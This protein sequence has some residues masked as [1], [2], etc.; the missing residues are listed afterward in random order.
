ME[1][2]HRTHREHTE[3]TQGTH[4]EHTENTLRP[5]SEY[6]ENTHRTARAKSEPHAQHNSRKRENRI[7]PEEQQQ[8]Q[9]E[10][11]VLQNTLSYHSRQ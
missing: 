10:Y 7:G 1:D 8:E 6:T 3:N 11:F 2:T 4:R 5:H 9:Q